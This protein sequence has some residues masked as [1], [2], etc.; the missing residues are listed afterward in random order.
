MLVQELSGNTVRVLGVAITSITHNTC[1]K[2]YCIST[3]PYTHEH[4]QCGKVVEYHA[5]NWYFY[6][7]GSW[8]YR[9]DDLINKDIKVDTETER[10]EK[11]K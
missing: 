10:V 11:Q 1:I 8:S 9:L 7:F 6:P 5:Q 3:M 2:S 4:D